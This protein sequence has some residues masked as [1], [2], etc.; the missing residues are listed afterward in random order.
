MVTLQP[1]WAEAWN[2]RA[3]VFFMM[4]DNSARWPTSR[5]VLAREP[6]HYGALAGMGMILQAHGDTS[7]AY[8]AFK[9][10][11]AINPFLEEVKS[12]VESLAPETEGRDI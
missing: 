10:A 1:G 2:K 8:H 5:E 4:G 9:R 12:A 7:S 6:R 11:L 3:T